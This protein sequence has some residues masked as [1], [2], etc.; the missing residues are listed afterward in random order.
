[1]RDAWAETS[2]GAGSMAPPPTSTS[3]TRSARGSVRLVFHPSG[4][5]VGAGVGGDGGMAGSSP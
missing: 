1:M 4:D 5:S 2:A 3:R